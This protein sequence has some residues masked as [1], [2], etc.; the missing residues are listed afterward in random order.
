[1][2][3]TCKLLNGHDLARSQSAAQQSRHQV[4]GRAWGPRFPFAAAL[5]CLILP[6]AAFAQEPLQI[7][8]PYHCANGVTYTILECKPY[9][10]DQMCT[11]REEQNGQVITTAYSLRSQMTGRL[12][13]CTVAAASQKPVTQNPAPLAGNPQAL[14]PSYLKEFPAVDQVL[15]KLK[16]SDANDTTNRQLGAFR[17]LKLV[18]QDLAGSRWYKNQLTADEK[19]IYGEYDL[20][21]NKIAQPLNF[22]LDGYYGRP[23]FIDTLFK[24]FSMTQVRAQWEQLNADFAARHATTGG[25]GQPPPASSQP[26]TGLP[27]TNDPT[28]LA[29]RR[30][31]ELGGGTLECVGSGLS[32]GFISFI[33]VNLDALKPPP[34]TGL[35]MTGAYKSSSGFTF[36]FADDFV[37]V[38]NCGKL[39]TAS[40]KYEVQKLMNQFAIKIENEPQAFLI[41][42][43]PDGRITAPA[44]ATIA[45][46]VII[47]YQSQIVETID[48]T[49]NTVV[50]G[51]AHTVQVPIYAPKT[52]RCAI[53]GMAPGP[54]VPPDN[55]FLSNIM[56]AASILFSDG[57]TPPSKENLISPGPRFLGNYASAGG[58]KFQ[59][60]SSSV[61]LDCAQA[62]VAAL[63]QVTNTTGGVAITVKNGT[64]PFTLV[65]QANGSIAGSGTV[66]VNGRLMTGMNGDTP[67][68]SPTSASCA[69]GAL[70]A[71]K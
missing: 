15:S 25:S 33:G 58:L 21:Y 66:T 24:T 71:A 40:H 3:F 36:T 28:A 22:P 30:C 37:S 12:K 14:N 67:T 62:H 43:G 1:M 16:G 70:T 26:S 38:D 54:A 55:G 61:I 50:P 5:A 59:F 6:A 39:V 34:I 23:Q 60:R 46:Q 42:L 68:F 7:N 65:V 19:R 2:E 31:L 64:S 51:S 49:T 52:E 48:R 10:N 41:A 17:Q 56:N 11:W 44:A 45:G 27:P 8:A 13:G 57:A 47:G 69:L 63:Y 20:A 53:G 35:R 29:T 4:P 32:T 9:K 18:I